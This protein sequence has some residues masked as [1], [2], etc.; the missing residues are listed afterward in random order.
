MVHTYENLKIIDERFIA[1]YREHLRLSGYDEMKQVFH[2]DRLCGLTF[3]T[4]YLADRKPSLVAP[5][6][7]FGHFITSNEYRCVRNGFGL[8]GGTPYISLGEFYRLPTGPWSATTE[9]KSIAWEIIVLRDLFDVNPDYIQSCAALEHTVD[10]IRYEG[11]NDRDKIAWVAE[12]VKNWVAEFGTLADFERQWHTRCQMLPELLALET[13]RQNALS[14]DPVAAETFEYDIGGGLWT[15]ELKS[16]GH[17][18][19]EQH[20]VDIECTD[21]EGQVETEVF[22]TRRQALG[23][24]E[25]TV[26]LAYESVAEPTLVSIPSI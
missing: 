5:L 15:I 6:H 10:F 13:T 1:P 16:Y 2:G 21:A 9:G 11:G 12:K 3:P 19:A 23:W 25:R 7:E 26:A 20:L 24:I 4:G 18:K 22:D 14:E 8:R 17:G